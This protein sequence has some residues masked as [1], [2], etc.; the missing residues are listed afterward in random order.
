MPEVVALSSTIED[1]L[2]DLGSKPVEHKPTG[3]FMRHAMVYGLGAVAIQIVSIV[4]LPL[5]VRC[6]SAEE[7]GVLQ[8]LYRV[9]DVLNLC[10][11][12][13]GI[14]MAAHNF[15]GKAETEKERKHVAATVGWL[16]FIVLMICLGI[17]M[18]GAPFFARQLGLYDN[19][20]NAGMLLGFGVLA[21]MLQATT[22]MPLALMQA[23]LESTSFLISSLGIAICQLT[24]VTIS[25]IVFEA[26]VW[27]VILA[28]ASVY[29]F[30]GAVL[31]IREFS[32]ATAIPDWGQMVQVVKFA[33][34]FMPN[35]LL[36]FILHSGDQLILMKYWGAGAVGV[37]ALA[38]RIARSVTTFASDPLVQVWNAKMYEVDRR[39][40]RS[41]AF[42]KVYSRILSGFALGG[43]CAVLFQDEALA[44]LGAFAGA[45][46]LI[47]PLVLAHFLLVFG[48]LADSAMYV[49]R[50]TELKLWVGVGATIV[51][52]LAYGLLIPRFAEMGAAWATV[53]GYGAYCLLTILT[54]QS[55]FHVEFEFRR[56]A[57]IFVS[58]VAVSLL[59]RLIAD[60]T[61]LKAALLAIV[62][63]TFWRSGI[64]Q[65]EEKQL[66]LSLAERA[67]GSAQERISGAWRG[68][69]R[70]WQ[71][72][73]GVRP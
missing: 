72:I 11:M 6:L 17:I 40:D 58:A 28:M 57:I 52:L 23:R 7:Y 3:G 59:G 14:Q 39:E 70:V 30:F 44:L 36:F 63:Y 19:Y 55:I 60:Y 49:R 2:D 13:S 24:A 65:D 15:W 53:I 25:L 31:T 29:A 9:G 43:V 8:L 34:P 45:E 71:R 20:D 56:I 32:R 16:T 64:V 18:V 27:G 68:V 41:T 21:M 22:M 35:G 26:G 46:K 12:V 48:N 69:S 4:L 37:Y 51:M 33:L 73:V 67:W 50:R 10:L 62:L 47:A 61:I 1:T 38:Y 42:G 66:I 5:Y 54:A